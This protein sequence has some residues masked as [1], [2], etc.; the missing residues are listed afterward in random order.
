MQ[1]KEWVVPDFRRPLPSPQARPRA[2]PGPD[3]AVAERQAPQGG[4][5]VGR[6]RGREVGAYPERGRTVPEN[7][8]EELDLRETKAFRMAV[9]ARAYLATIDRCD[10]Q[11]KVNL[12]AR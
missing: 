2:V 6:A 1:F 12:L 11:F 10:V 9:G 4:A 7:A 3:G 5:T 8:D